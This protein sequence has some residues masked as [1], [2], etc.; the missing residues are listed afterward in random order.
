ML[1]LPS[2][3]SPLFVALVLYLC[4]GCLVSHQKVGFPESVRTGL[5]KPLL[6]A[7]LGVHILSVSPSVCTTSTAARTAGL[8]AGVG[9]PSTRLEA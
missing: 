6:L 2:F 9:L 8:V 3:V 4:A 1:A 7:C 5:L